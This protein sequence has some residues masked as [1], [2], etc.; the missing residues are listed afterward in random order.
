MSAAPSGLPLPNLDDR[1]WAD[2]VEEGRALIPLYAP[3]WTDHNASDPGITLVE[4]LAWLA[5]QQVFRIDR[6]GHAGLVKLLRLAGGVAVPPRPSRAVLSVAPEM[7]HPPAQVAAGTEFVGKAPGGGA[8]GFRALDPATVASTCLRSVQT[9]NGAMFIDRLSSLARG[10]PVPIWGDRP[11]PG[12]AFVLGF[13]EALPVDSEFSIYFVVRPPAESDAERSRIVAEAGEGGAAR[14]HSVRL[15]WEARMASGL[16]VPLA[17]RDETRALT[18]NGRV[19]LRGSDLM[20]KSTLGQFDD[21]WFYVRARIVSGRHD[22]E[23]LL[24]AVIVNAVVVEQAVIPTGSVELDPPPPPGT[25]SW[26]TRFEPLA[27]GDGWPGQVRRVGSPEV[28]NGAIVVL[29]TGQE[30]WTT[31]R[32]RPDFDA[33]R[34]TSADY[35]L[36]AERGTITF[37]DGERGR[38]LAGREISD[39]TISEPEVPFV[40]YLSTLADA[41]NVPAGSVDGLKVADPAIKAIVQPLPAWGG[42][43]AET[44]DDVH[45]RVLDDLLAVHRAVTAEDCERLAKEAPGGAIAIARATAESHPDLPGVPCPGVVSLIILP[46]L[47][48]GRPEPTPGLCHLVSCYVNRRAVPGSRVEV[49]SPVYRRVLVEATIRIFPGGVAATV[50]ASAEASLRRAFHPLT[51]GLMGLGWTIGRDVYHAEV[52]RVLG[53]APGV[54]GV[55]FLD[56]SLDGGPAR[57]GNLCLGPR[58]LPT[59]DPP[60]ITIAPAIARDG[61]ACP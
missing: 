60:V 36:D 45:A 7:G 24:G 1:R 23:V 12:S 28:A 25:P 20:E 9:Q 43:A 26:A 27:P 3:E 51:G 55:T 39:G 56:L 31:W 11:G 59:L 47:P 19:L 16:W 17:A 29:T 15:A 49:A 4:L 14:H 2:L 52:L 44:T 18:L 22:A 40:A 34:R 32:A 37:G 35:V 42:L 21:R 46:S 5:E 13:D 6:L 30:G 41:G 10:E 48:E 57:C 58:G 8:V 61:R 54:A 53:A 38:T 50:L 33:S